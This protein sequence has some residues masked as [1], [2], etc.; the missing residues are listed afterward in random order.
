ME[1]FTVKADITQHKVR[2]GVVLR[3]ELTKLISRSET[4]PFDNNGFRGWGKRSIHSLEIFGRNSKL[5]GG[6]KDPKY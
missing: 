6:E 2:V 3:S 1:E 4:K 5:G